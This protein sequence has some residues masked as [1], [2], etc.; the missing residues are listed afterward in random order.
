MADWSH[1]DSVTREFFV[2]GFLKKDK[3]TRDAVLQKSKTA[4]HSVRKGNL[5][6]ITRGEV[7]NDR[8]AG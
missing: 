5:R 3:V 1:A 2:S 7:L 4:R 8:L 6:N